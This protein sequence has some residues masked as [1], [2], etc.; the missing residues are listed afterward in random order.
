[1]FGYSNLENLNEKQ[2]KSIVENNNLKKICKHKIRKYY[3]DVLLPNLI[4]R[5]YGTQFYKI[6]D[7]IELMTIQMLLEPN[8]VIETYNKICEMFQIIN[9]L[10]Y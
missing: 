1:M 7:L 4:A 8:K 3:Y 10:L 6:L 2:F 5:G 9:C